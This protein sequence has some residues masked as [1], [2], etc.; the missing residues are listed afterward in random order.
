MKISSSSEA[1]VSYHMT[2]WPHNPENHDL[3]E[4]RLRY[5]LIQR[6]INSRR[7]TTIQQCTDDSSSRHYNSFWIDSRISALLDHTR[8]PVSENKT[9]N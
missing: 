9:Q 8:E 7:Y 1:L 2:S 5:N 6:S 4:Y 3:K